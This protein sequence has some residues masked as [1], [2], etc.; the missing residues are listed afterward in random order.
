MN[1]IRPATVRVLATAASVAVAIGAVVLVAQALSLRV[2]EE[3]APGIPSVTAREWCLSDSPSVPSAQ[4]RQVGSMYFDMTFSTEDSREVELA[5]P[6]W[7]AACTLT[8]ELWGLSNDEWQWCFSEDVRSAYL[9]PAVA[10]LSM[11]EDEAAGIDRFTEAPGDDPAEYTQA[12]RFAHRFWRHTAV[13]VDPGSEAR[14]YYAVDSAT[15][16]WCDANPA[17]VGDA[18]RQLGLDGDG[19]SQALAELVA[20]TR[21]CTVARIVAEGRAMPSSTLNPEPRA[22]PAPPSVIFEA[23][24]VNQTRNAFFL[25]DV[26]A[27]G[28]RSQIIPPCSAVRINGETRSLPWSLGYG[29]ASGSAG[30]APPVPPTDVQSVLAVTDPSDGP[31]VGVEIV[32]DEA[33]TNVDKKLPVGG[34]PEGDLCR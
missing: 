34:M 31:R 28:D 22:T 27:G 10:F 18:G 13:G 4:V 5:D 21:A 14:A 25:S 2:V 33:G 15:Q 29:R 19:G 7:E 11:G 20:R 16:A 1:S 24:V 3:A 6:R 8:F 23:L 9:V 32:F 30:D 12:C 26:P 17:A